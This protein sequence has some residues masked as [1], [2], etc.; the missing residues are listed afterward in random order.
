MRLLPNQTLKSFKNYKHA[1]GRLKSQSVSKT[2]TCYRLHLQCTL[3]KTDCE[4]A[5]SFV[6]VHPI[7]NFNCDDIS[8][9]DAKDMVIC[10]LVEVNRQCLCKGLEFNR[11]TVL[12][13]Q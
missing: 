6:L 10:G 5:C 11:A 9:M 4:R 2:E 12:R 8:T 13:Q 7:G 1:S 3:E